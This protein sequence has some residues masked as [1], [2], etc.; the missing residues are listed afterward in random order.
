M[1]AAGGRFIVCPSV[2]P[3]CSA[4]G[5]LYLLPTPDRE[6]RLVRAPYGTWVLDAIKRMAEV[7]LELALSCAPGDERDVVRACILALAEDGYLREA[8]QLQGDGH[9]LRYSR[10]QRYFAQTGVRADHAQR[11]LARS[12][13]LVVGLGG[14]GGPVAEHLVRCGIGQ[15]IGLDPDI[16]GEENLARQSLYEPG[17]V[18]RPK[19]DC[20]HERLQRLAHGS[21]TRLTMINARATDEQSLIDLVLAYDVDIMVAAADS[22]PLTIKQWFDEAAFATGI[23]VAMAGHRPPYVY[24]GPLIVPGQSGCFACFGHYASNGDPLIDELNADRDN[25]RFVVPGLGYLD[26]IAAGFLVSDVV[27]LLTGTHNPSTFGRELE[28]DMRSLETRWLEPARTECVR[29]ARGE[30][31]RE[32]AA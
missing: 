1:M 15:V 7:E 25:G 13:V 29:C 16:V 18:G 11:A 26:A 28:I 24:V 23:P 3:F 22:P 27:G 20:A 17:Q 4:E 2:E 19:A 6:Q 21:Q 10:Q 9:D 30:S 32:Q 31:A 5:N 8:D 12:S 14:L